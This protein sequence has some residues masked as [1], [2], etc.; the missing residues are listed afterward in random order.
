MSLESRINRLE[1]LAANTRQCQEQD[2]ADAERARAKIAED[3]LK[4]QKAGMGGWS[5]FVAKASK[6]KALEMFVH[7]QRLRMFCNKA[8]LPESEQIVNG[9]AFGL[10]SL[11]DQDYIQEA[12]D[13]G[14]MKRLLNS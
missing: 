1:G 6:Q 7:L 10:F 5:R 9:W 8:N 14:K 2:Q 13:N 4:M 12:M 3:I 11:M